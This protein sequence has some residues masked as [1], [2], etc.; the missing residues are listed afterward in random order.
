[1]LFLAIIGKLFKL[2]LGLIITLFCG[3]IGWSILAGK[4]VLNG[5]LFS[6]L[7][8]FRWFG[9]DWGLLDG[10]VIKFSL[11]YGLCLAELDDGVFIK[12]RGWMGL[13]ITSGLL[14]WI[15][16]AC[17]CSIGGVWSWPNCLIIL[18]YFISVAVVGFSSK[19]GLTLELGKL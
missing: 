3:D 6:V 16:W 18:D 4:E 11:F 1:M 17:Y 15:I 13:I 5:K 19:L 9:K 7:L 10:W 2:G 14:F 8:L 12:I